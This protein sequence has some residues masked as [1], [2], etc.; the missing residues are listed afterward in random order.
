[1]EPDEAANDTKL[2]FHRGGKEGPIIATAEPCSEKPLQTDI[3]FVSTNLTVPLKHK[4]HSHFD[5][6]GKA[7][8]WTGHCFRGKSELTEDGTG[9]NVAVFEPSVF[10]GNVQRIHEG[11]LTVTYHDSRDIV[12]ITALV[13]QVRAEEM[14]GPVWSLHKYG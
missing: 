4:H 8:S 10:E 9:E 11:D 6:N 2:I 7:Y 12:V 13:L 5:D 1:M 3:H 14:M